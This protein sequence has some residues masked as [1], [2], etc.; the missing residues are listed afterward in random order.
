MPIVA[1]ITCIFVGFV[2]KPKTVIEEVELSGEFKRRRAF[3]VII[4]YIAPVCIIAILVSSVLS[5]FGILNI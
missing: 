2:L 3:S 5:A 1:F 4:T